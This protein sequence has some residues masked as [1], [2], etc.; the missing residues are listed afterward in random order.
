M[1]KIVYPITEE[2]FSDA[3]KYANDKY[4]EFKKKRVIRLFL[5]VF[6]NAAFLLYNSQAWHDIR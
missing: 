6:A 2:N 1:K 3:W 4:A 5:K